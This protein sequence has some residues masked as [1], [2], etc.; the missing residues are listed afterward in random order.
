MN[1]T[2]EG[3]QPTLSDSDFTYLQPQQARMPPPR[4]LLTV[5][6]ARSS[7]STLHLLFW[8]FRGVNGRVAAAVGRADEGGKDGGL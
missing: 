2:F 6:E 5:V 7:S 4:R 3:E 8:C 1:K